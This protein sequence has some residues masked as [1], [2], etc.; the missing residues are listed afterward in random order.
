MLKTQYLLTNIYRPVKRILKTFDICQKAKYSTKLSSGPMANILPE[1]PLELIS[2]DLMG[3]L[4]RGPG[5]IKYF[6][7]ILDIFS[8][9]IKI[10]LLKRATMEII[11]KRL[12]HEYIPSIEGIEK[13][14]TDNNTQF[15]SIKWS[16][17]LQKLDVKIIHT[18]PYYPES[19]PVER[20]NRDLPYFEV[21]LSCKIYKLVE[22][23]A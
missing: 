13:I 14:L 3:P 15:W 17:V 9:Y 19:N 6:L 21:I 10:S 8:K 1:K 22:V 12:T 7:A 4:P 18:T 5:G 20:V 23:D 2:L 16:Q 11:L